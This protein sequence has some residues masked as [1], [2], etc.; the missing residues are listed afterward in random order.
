MKNNKKN[1]GTQNRYFALLFSFIIAILLLLTLYG[2]RSETS[3]SED[4]M[5]EINSDGKTCTVIG[6]NEMLFNEIVIPDS[7]NGY[8][9][10]GIADYAFQNQKMSSV[11]LPSTIEHIGQGAFADCTFLKS[12]YG[13]E[14]CLYIQSIENKTFYGCNKLTKI[15]LPPNLVSIG[16]SAFLACQSL[17]SIELPNSL[18]TISQRAFA[19][20]TSLLSIKFPDDLKYIGGVAFAQCHAL[21]EV[22]L[23]PNLSSSQIA[24][25]FVCCN[26]LNNIYVSDNSQSLASVDGVLF[27]KN[28]YTLYAYPSGRISKTYAIPS[29]VS[30]IYN[31]AFAYNVYL[32]EINIPNSIDFI[33]PYVLENSP[34]L[35]TINYEGTIKE[36]QLI[37]KYS[38]WDTDSADYT[39]YCTDGQIAKNGTVTYK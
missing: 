29:G 38:N 7:Y 21:K 9:V 20:C 14:N 13:L 6:C 25:P 34:N 16:D 12:I 10:T 26:A 27:D 11:T 8:T 33:Y 1:C 35:T 36:W 19:G 37:Y 28:I 30:A 32:T 22:C 15:K 18:E 4:L 31:M 3:K 39:I 23:P 5:Y 2:C 24:G 17:I